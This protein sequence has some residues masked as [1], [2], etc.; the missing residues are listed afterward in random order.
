M[1]TTANVYVLN[2]CHFKNLFDYFTFKKK[3]NWIFLA[4]FVCSFSLFI[5][6]AG[7]YMRNKR[8]THM[9]RFDMA[10]Q[11]Q[12]VCYKF[13]QPAGGNDKRLEH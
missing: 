6:I 7:L 8:R 4:C 5:F 3:F 9:T 2:Y 13:R 1:L 12:L 11:K 10:S